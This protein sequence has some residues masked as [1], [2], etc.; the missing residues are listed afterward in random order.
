[1]FVFFLLFAWKL[2]ILFLYL[3]HETEASALWLI[4][5]VIK[6][7]FYENNLYLS[8][9]LC[10]SFCTYAQQHVSY[11]YDAAGNRVSRTI[12]LQSRAARSEALQNDSSFVQERLVDASLCIYPNPVQ[13][14][15]TISLT[16]GQYQTPAIYSLLDTKGAQLKRGRLQAGSMWYCQRIPNRQKK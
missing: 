6:T 16:D 9:F 8:R 11:P 4:S 14:I 7:W 2:F 13:S 10:A 1:M 12:V 3:Q 15:L 5:C